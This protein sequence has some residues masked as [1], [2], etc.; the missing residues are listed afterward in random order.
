MAWCQGRCPTWPH[1]LLTVCLWTAWAEFL[2]AHYKTSIHFIEGLPFQ[3]L[4]IFFHSLHIV[5]KIYFSLIHVCVIWCHDKN[6]LI[7]FLLWIINWAFIIFSILQ[8]IIMLITFR[9]CFKWHTSPH[10][11]VFAA[12]P[13]WLFQSHVNFVTLS[14]F[15]LAWRCL[16]KASG[17]FSSG[18]SKTS[19]P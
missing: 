7:S 18:Q 15:L 3:C 17:P 5:H 11:S 16:S 1:N 4:S 6:F 9:F 12:K 13:F 14:C 10:G 2:I 19:N 8:N